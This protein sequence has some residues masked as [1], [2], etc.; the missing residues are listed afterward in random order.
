[1]PVGLDERQIAAVWRRLA[2]E[3]RDESRRHAWR[4]W[5]LAAVTAVVAV[6]LVNAPWRRVRTTV[7]VVPDA[8]PRP[9]T[10]AAAPLAP[11][12]SPA[13]REWPLDDGSSI[14]LD[15]SARLEIVSNERGRFVTKLVGGRASFDVRPGGPRTWSIETSLAT[16]EVVGT[17]FD[18]ADDGGTLV[19]VKVERGVVLVK[20]ERVPGRIVRLVAGQELIVEKEERR[21]MEPAPAPPPAPE[22]PPRRSRS[23]QAPNP[24]PTPTLTEM[25]DE[26]DRLRKAGRAREAAARLEAVIATHPDDGSLGVAAFSLGR[27]YLEVLDEPAAAAASFAKVLSAGR[28][29]DLLEL[30]HARRIEALW[31]AGASAELEAAL[32]AFQAAFPDSPELVELR[33]RIRTSSPP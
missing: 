6:A 10:L 12:S 11:G 8:P 25:L 26:A 30:A 16:I 22:P 20:G 17:A 24:P 9:L 13:E 2:Q 32:A 4:W 5:V 29:A 33:A 18:V 23:T 15:A 14:R 31:R 1:M 19:K 3:R 27:L 28:P 21:T 7:A